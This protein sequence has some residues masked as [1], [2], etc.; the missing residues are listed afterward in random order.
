MIVVDGFIWLLIQVVGGVSLG[1]LIAE[2]IKAWRT[3]R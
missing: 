3:R 1:Y 2:G